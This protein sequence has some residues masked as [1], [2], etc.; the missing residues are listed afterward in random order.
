[1]FF[2]LF[3]NEYIQGSIENVHF[4]LSSFQEAAIAVAPPNEWPPII[5]FSKSNYA[6]LLKP[7]VF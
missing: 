3:T 4:I 6:L 7:K 2:K 5:N 1:L